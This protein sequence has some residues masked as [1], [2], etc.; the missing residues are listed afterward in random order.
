MWTSL[1][2]TM[3]AAITGEWFYFRFE[4][5][6]VLPFWKARCVLLTCR[7]TCRL[8]VDQIFKLPFL[9]LNF[10]WKHFVIL[11]PY[12]FE[13][14]AAR[15]GRQKTR[16]TAHWRPK[17]RGSIFVAEKIFKIG[18]GKKTGLW[19]HL[20]PCFWQVATLEAHVLFTLLQVVCYKGRLH[21]AGVSKYTL[22]LL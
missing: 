13:S 1:C 21:R 11:F 8:P 20:F 19:G 3:I 18:N 9:F 5:R 4:P 2:K 12:C 7:L 10:R 22:C 15:A 17:S 6:A 14:W 16:T